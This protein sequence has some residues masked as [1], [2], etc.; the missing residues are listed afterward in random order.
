M[1]RQ[2]LFVGLATLDIIY[3]VERL[4]R[5]NEKIAALDCA[6]AAGGPA[7]NAAVTFASR[8]HQATLAAVFGQHALSE[9]VRAELQTWNLRLCDLGPDYS[10]PLPLSSAT[11]IASSGDRAV[12]SLNARNLQADP[13]LLPPD[14][15]DE[16]DVV[17]IDGHQLAASQAIASQARARQIPV[18]L[19]GGSWKMGLETLLPAVSYA[20]CSADFFPPN[21]QQT[22]AVVAYLQAQGIENIAIA[23]GD[24]PIQYWQQDESG[25][26]P[27]PSVQAVDTLG[28]GDILHGAFCAEIGDREFVEAL[29]AAAELAS[30]SCQFLGTRAGLRAPA[31]G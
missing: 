5:P 7:T 27:V 9:V 21:C 4:P 23:A 15:L 6:I 14:L 22:E 13:A 30:H 19:D 26:L 16:I 20:I 1:N 31:V 25:I 12:V 2:G 8:G 17:L 11:A 3:Q 10:Q 29:A 28:A 24:R 18:V